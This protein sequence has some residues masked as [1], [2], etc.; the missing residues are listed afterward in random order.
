M[1]TG[2]LKGDDYEA[3]LA[4]G[5]RFGSIKQ[6]KMVL[7]DLAIKRKFMFKVADENKDTFAA[8]CKITGCKW[9]IRA[10]NLV[11]G[12]TVTRSEGRHTCDILISS[13][14]HPLASHL[15]IARKCHGLHKDSNSIKTVNI[16]QY[17]EKHWGVKVNYQRAWRAKEE[18]IRLIDGNPEDAYRI[19][20]HYAKEL[21]WCNPGTYV[22]IERCCDIPEIENEEAG[23]EFRR[24]FWIFG[25]VARAFQRSLRQ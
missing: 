8:K 13:K 6:F 12:V 14:D 23:Y 24:V 18:L 15:W 5:A 20:P 16:Q 9:Y 7:T 25:P 1:L 17:I 11:D 3:Q 21:E 10:S 19:L 2:N 4:L 22:V